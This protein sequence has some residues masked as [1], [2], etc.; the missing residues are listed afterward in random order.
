MTKFKENSIILKITPAALIEASGTPKKFPGSTPGHGY[1]TPSRNPRIT[2]EFSL[3]FDENKFFIYLDSSTIALQ[4]LNCCWCCSSCA[5]RVVVMTGWVQSGTVG[6]SAS[7]AADAPGEEQFASL[8]QLP[9]THLF[10]WCCCCCRQ[11][12]G[13]EEDLDI[14]PEVPDPLLDFFFDNFD[15]DGCWGCWSCSATSCASCT[16]TDGVAGECSCAF[17]VEC[18]WNGVGAVR[19]E[20]EI[21]AA[22]DGVEE[23][24]GGGGIRVRE[25]PN[26]CL[27]IHTNRY[28]IEK[29]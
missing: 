9:C 3:K 24:D 19:G 2:T 27:K 28:A 15:E 17:P 18:R 7:D 12:S 8:A 5:R 26:D 29:L 21:K 23:E 10:C 4:L 11:S 25:E 1:S 16:E 22:V 13:F 14:F 6:H 20:E